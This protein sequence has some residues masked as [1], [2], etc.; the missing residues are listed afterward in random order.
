MRP[1]RSFLFTPGNHPRK[2]AKVFTVGADAA[3]LD[4]EDAVAGAEKEATRAAIV[5][6]LAR[7]R[8]GARPGARPASPPSRAYVRVNALDTPFAF[9]D[10]EA[11]VVAGLDGIVLPK[12]E[13][14]ADLRAADWM[15]AALERRRGLAEGAVDLMP[16]VETARGLAAAREI[17]SHGGRVARV[18]FGAGDY[19]RDLG[20]E[21][22][23]AEDELDPARA[24]IVLAS[25]LAGL[26]PPVDTVFA[27][28]SEPEAFRASCSRVRRMGFQGKLLIHP[29]QVAP[30]NAAF[31]P[32]PEEVARAR[33][34][35][36]AFRAAEAAGSASIRVGGQFVDYPIVAR[37][38][39]IVALAEA[40]GGSE[41]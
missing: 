18:S 38:E 41:T 34:I 25:R 23:A 31:S 20:M 37:A 35:V 13:S 7:P 27:R 9:G 32:A 14:A 29:D 39:R 17:C 2:V 22:T 30:A 1:G 28:L 3:I 8:P 6:A 5:E 33:G 12:V 19:T 16:I 24:E 36:A 4:L 10:I 15:I 21:W 40:I 26:E 11:V